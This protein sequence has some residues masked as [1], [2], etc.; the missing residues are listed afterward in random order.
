MQ[1]WYAPSLASAAEAGVADWDLP[2]IVSLLKTGQSPRGQVTGPM[3]EVVRH[4]T[5]YLNDA[6]LNAMATYL[7]ALPQVP[8][9]AKPA[10]TAI[11]GQKLEHGAK[12]Y[13]K[14]CAQCHGDQGEGVPGAYPALAGNRAVTLPQTVNL[15]QTLLYGGFAPA[16][17]GN[18][19]PF[20]MPP[21]VLV[22]N[23]A[24]IADVLTHL[25]TAWGKAAPE[26]TELEVNRVRAAQGR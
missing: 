11:S 3:A 8:A 4:S 19:R 12:L 6:D 10:N 17:A 24:D 22:L 25:R 7:K 23:D 26:V 9:L 21:F 18:P 2:Q 13:E 16:T 20:G 1:N 5:Q 14:H 15:V